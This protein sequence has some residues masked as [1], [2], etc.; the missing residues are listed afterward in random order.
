MRKTKKLRRSSQ[1]GGVMRIYNYTEFFITLS[2]VDL[3][4]KRGE[5]TIKPYGNAELPE[6]AH[7][8]IDEFYKKTIEV[9]EQ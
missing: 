3:Q 8:N 1:E 6:P 5:I 7:L 9:K 4:G 2:Y